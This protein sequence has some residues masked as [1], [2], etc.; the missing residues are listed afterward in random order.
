[1]Q[2]IPGSAEAEVQEEVEVSRGIKLVDASN[3]FNDLLRL[4]MLCTIWNLLT[5]GVKFELN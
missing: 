4:A 1:M 2:E 5:E 3:G